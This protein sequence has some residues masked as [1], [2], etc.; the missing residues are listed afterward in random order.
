MTAYSLN[1][2]CVY[3]WSNSWIHT[4]GKTIPHGFDDD[5][6]GAVQWAWLEEQLKDPAP[7]KLV[8]SGIQVCPYRGDSDITTSQLLRG[9][10][11]GCGRHSCG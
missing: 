2:P 8:G 3:P 1:S 9:W 10:G 11:A 6:L 5:M 7:V 4:G